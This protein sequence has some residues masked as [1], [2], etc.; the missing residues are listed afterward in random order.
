MDDTIDFGTPSDSSFKSSRKARGYGIAGVGS[1]PVGDSGWSGFLRL[2]TIDAHT[3]VND[4]SIGFVPVPSSN[5]TSDDWRAYYGL[6]V[7]W[8]FARNWGLR[9][10]WD[11]CH[12]L[13]NANT[14]GETNIDFAN[15]GL[16]VRF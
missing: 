10:G 1:I 7:A 5:T 3:Q 9:L 15:V 6:G 12:D 14:G 11:Q 8:Q 2:G 13:A 16:P 4:T